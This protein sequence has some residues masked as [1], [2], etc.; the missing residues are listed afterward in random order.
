MNDIKDAL[1]TVADASAPAPL[2]LERVR[3]R[4]GQIRRRRTAAA[5]VG[6]AAAVAA[7][8]GIGVAVSPSGSPDRS[9]PPIAK[10][11]QPTPRTDAADPSAVGPTYAVTLD[12]PAEQ[13]FGDEPKVPYWSDGEIVDADGSTTPLA[14]RPFTFAWDP[15]RAS[16]TVIRA[17]EAHAEILRIGKDGTTLTPPRPTFDRGLAVGPG[18][19]LAVMEEDSDGWTLSAYGSRVSLGRSVEY[20]QIDG[21]LANGDVVD[22]LDGRT[23]AADV[24]AGTFTDLPD[25]SAVV[26]SPTVRLTATAGEDGTW[27]A[28]DGT[29]STHWS[30]DWAGVS[31]FSPD[32]RHVV[33]SGDPQQRIQGSTDW[34]S[35]YATSTLWIRTAAD[36]LPEAAF[37][38]PQGGY[39]WGWTW[40]G[41]TLV[42]N[43]FLDGRWTLVR[44]ATDGFTVGPGTTTPGRTEQP[45]Y[46][47]ATQ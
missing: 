13:T 10:T 17:G 34:D 22:T 11:P 38:A 9:L 41:D 32:G 14:D 29:G 20:G 18:G 19:E 23:R 8:A 25:A 36:L 35:G 3:G 4:A 28:R 15:S 27:T 42:T 16:W 39:F 37:V 40:D 46:V 1:S 5:I 7:I 24:V 33:L 12:V 21:F 26:T 47:F 30:L 2:A 45:A 44:L 31:S 6:S 43:L